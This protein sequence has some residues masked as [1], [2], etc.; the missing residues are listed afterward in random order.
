MNRLVSRYSLL[1][2][3]IHIPG[4]RANLWMKHLSRSK[5]QV[6]DRNYTEGIK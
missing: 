6:S 5:R 4:A 1:V 3:W 2:D